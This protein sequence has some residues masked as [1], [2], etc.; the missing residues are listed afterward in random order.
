MC[1]GRNDCAGPRKP[2][3]RGLERSAEER[4][5][6]DRR[7]AER[8]S[9]GMERADRESRWR[10]AFD[11]EEAARQAARDAEIGAW[12][13][14]VRPT[15]KVGDLIFTGTPAG[16]GPV[17]PGDRLVGVLEGEEMFAVNVK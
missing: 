15:L 7:R 9:A 10:E 2:D 17:A 4:L 12:R 16:V 13:R 5:A 1:D 11:A 14:D 8:E 3:A 6:L